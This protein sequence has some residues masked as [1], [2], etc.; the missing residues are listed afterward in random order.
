MAWAVHARNDDG[1][2]P[3]GTARD[4]STGGMFIRTSRPH[5]VG[6]VL[7]FELRPGDALPAIAAAAAAGVRLGIEP[8]HPMY[9]GKR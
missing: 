2:L 1:L 3:R 4:V 5:P 6:A 8:L 7:E 9:A